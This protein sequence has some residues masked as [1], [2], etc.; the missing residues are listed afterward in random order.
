MGSRS[1]V[2]VVDNRARNG[3]GVGVSYS[4]NSGVVER[5]SALSMA[6]GLAP[7]RHNVVPGVTPGPA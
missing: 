3:H 6:P 2:L 1:Q 7:S 5:G 4:V